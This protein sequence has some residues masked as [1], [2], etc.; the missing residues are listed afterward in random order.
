VVI[1]GINISTVYYNNVFIGAL[2][3]RIY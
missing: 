2:L 1:A 3:V